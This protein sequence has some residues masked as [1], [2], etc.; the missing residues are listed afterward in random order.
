MLLKQAITFGSSWKISKAITWPL[1]SENV[2]SG[3]ILSKG[4]VKEYNTKRGCGIIEDVETGQQ[5]TV[6]A[7]YIKDG[8]I[9]VEGQ[10]VEYELETKRN[11]SWAI[12][13]KIL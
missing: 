10:D 2:F 6:Y 9:L 13:V 3:G 4:K 1:I 5:M 11:D 8:D 7:N 12:N